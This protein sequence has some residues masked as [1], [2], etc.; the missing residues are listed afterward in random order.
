ML[1]CCFISGHGSGCLPALQL[2][3]LNAQALLMFH[4]QEEILAL[5][6]TMLNIFTPSEKDH[7]LC[8]KSFQRLIW[9]CMV[10]LEI[11]QGWKWNKDFNILKLIVESIYLRIS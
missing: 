9:K 2:D 8:L 3:V 5:N 7:W 1:L 4:L 11:M 6:W 10:F